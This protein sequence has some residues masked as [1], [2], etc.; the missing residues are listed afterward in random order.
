MSTSQE[1]KKEIADSGRKLLKSGLTHGT[2]G[3]LSARI[4]GEEKVVIS[5]SHVPYE[6]IQPE[7]VLVIDLAGEVLEG[8]RNPS[9]ESMMH[10][11]IYKARADVGAIVHAHSVYASALA[12]VGKGIPAFLDE[13]VAIVGGTTEVAKYAMPGTSEL[14]KNVL[15]ALGKKNAVLLANHGTVCCG[16]N[17]ARAFEMAEGIERTAKIYVLALIIGGPKMLSDEVVELQQN[18]FE[19]LKQV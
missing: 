6:S 9:V 13:I 1:L 5:P 4:P 11:E 18:S 8:E 14:A 17:L 15:R 7:D 10:L 3:N 12:S 16:R 2:A 19:L